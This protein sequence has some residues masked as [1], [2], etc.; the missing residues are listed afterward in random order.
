M[1]EMKRTTPPKKNASP[2]RPPL[3]LKPQAPEPARTPEALAAMGDGEL[4]YM[5]AF[6]AAELRHLFPQTEKVHPSVQLFALF[7]ADGS[8]LMLAD[9]RELVISGAW[10]NDLD[11]AT[12]H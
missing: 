3:A 1:A 12:V 4:A 5:R 6:R 2:A 9:S 11:M 10:Q 8:P 7:A